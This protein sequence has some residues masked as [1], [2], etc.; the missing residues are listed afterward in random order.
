MR[1][2]FLKLQDDNKKTKK[3]RLEKLSEGLKEIEMV[4]HYQGFL[5][6]PKIIYSELISKH[7]SNPVLGHFGIKKTQKQITKMYY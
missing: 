2:R 7:H 1:I 4:F 6:V 3:L 5:Y